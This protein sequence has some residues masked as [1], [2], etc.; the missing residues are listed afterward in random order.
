[1]RK[2]SDACLGGCD[3][4]QAMKRRLA[5]FA[6]VISGLYLLVVGPMPDP[7]PL[8]DEGI[9]LMIFVASMKVLGHDV[10]RWLP[11]IGKGKVPSAGRTMPK[12]KNSTVDV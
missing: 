10:T 6:A 1:M 5:L 2:F 11:F 3:T 9:M 7:I 8:V 4:L 12:A